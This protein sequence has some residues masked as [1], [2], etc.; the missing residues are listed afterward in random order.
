MKHLESRIFW[1]IVLIAAGVLFL[2]QNLG[3]PILDNLWP[4]VFGVAGLV[5]LYYFLTERH[6]WW[7]AIPGLTLLGLSAL[8]A[9]ERLFPK[10]HDNWGAAI[11]MASLS[12]SF[13][14][15]YVRTAAQQ[16]WAIIPAGVLGALAMLIGFEPYMPGGVFAALFL[17]SIAATFALV[18]LLPTPTGRMRWAAYPAVIVGGVGLFVLIGATWL[19]RVL[20]PLAIIAFGVYLLLRR[21]E[22]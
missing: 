10:A 19:S 13:L 3:L 20:V 15:V 5:F 11:F 22:E 4:L 7:A 12:L 6:N 9:F 16:W 18:Y 2:L 14:A 1:G 8:I 17:L 21:R